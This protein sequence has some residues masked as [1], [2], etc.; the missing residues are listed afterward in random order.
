R[1]TDWA[2]LLDR[3]ALPCQ[4]LW[5]YLAG[6]A[7]VPY[8]WMVEQSEWAT[9]LLFQDPQPL[10]A[11]YPKLLRHGIEVF[12]G[13]DVLR[14]LGRHVPAEGD[15]RGTGDA[16][17]DRRERSEGARLKMWYRHNALKRYDKAGRAL[18]GETPINQPGDFRVWRRPE[19]AAPDT[20]PSWQQMR[21]GVADL[22]ARGEE[23]ER[24]NGRLLEG[25]AAVQE[26]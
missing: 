2:A 8:Y 7:R 1:Q 22:A 25:L 19:G 5:D 20:P 3:L 21:K 16:S 12:S 10:A 6:V 9:D 26:S 4:P 24:C 13:K 23:S 15:G 14:Y 18:R 11:W 17:M